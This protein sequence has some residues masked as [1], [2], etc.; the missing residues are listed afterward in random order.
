M[1]EKDLEDKTQF[2]LCNP[3]PMYNYPDKGERLIFYYILHRGLVFRYQVW[4]N[5]HLTHTCLWLPPALTLSVKPFI[6]PYHS[7][8]LTQLGSR[9]YRSKKVFIQIL[10]AVR[11]Q[12]ALVYTQAESSQGTE[13]EQGHLRGPVYLVRSYAEWTGLSNGVE[14]SLASSL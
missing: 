6:T 8:L 7:L 1:K 5:T 4:M 3:V 12:D 13:P 14:V 10:L 11:K 9:P 2:I